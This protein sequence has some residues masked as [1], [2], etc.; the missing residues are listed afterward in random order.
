MPKKIY[1]YRN[2]SIGSS[3]AAERA[4]KTPKEI[5]IAAET[6]TAITIA[7]NGTVKIQ[8]KPRILQLTIPASLKQ[9]QIKFQ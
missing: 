5:P 2:A 8:V 1:S 7:Y 4:G 9:F 6:P 3:F